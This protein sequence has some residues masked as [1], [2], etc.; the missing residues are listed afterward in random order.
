[1]ATRVPDDS[2]RPT[3]GRVPARSGPRPIR[4]GDAGGI[5]RLAARAFPRSQAVFVRAGSEGFVVD[6]EDGLAAA[7]LLRTITL[8]GGRRIGF[9]AWAMTDPAHQGRGRASALARLGI[10]RLEALGCDTVITEIEGHNA[11]SEGA[12]RKLGFRRIGLGAQV[13]AFGLPGAARVRLG[14]GYS[15]DPGHF[16]WLRGAEPAPTVE[17]RERIL[18]WA[19]NGVFALLAVAMGGGLLLGGTPALPSSVEAG[20]ALMGVVL[21]LG[22]REAAMRMAARARGLAVTYRARDSGLGI[23]APVAV[24]FGS[25]F[26]LPGSVYPAAEGGPARDAG[27]ALATAAL[28][29]ALAVAMLVGLALWAGTALAGTMLATAASGVL[30]VGKPL[31]LFDTVMAFPPFHAFNARRIFEHHRGLWA[32]LAVIGALLFLL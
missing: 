22:A 7:V 24:L 3:G 19:I 18:A 6:G 16:I 28:A 1:M 32:G 29:G 8:S 27:P 23:T 30:F 11:A 15:T 5:A 20:F 26:P 13:A 25:L 12:F 9:V 10:A 21:L 14:I 31:V 2:S 4:P 17:G